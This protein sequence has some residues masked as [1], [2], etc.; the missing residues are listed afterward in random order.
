MC[1]LCSVEPAEAGAD[2]CKTC[3]PLSLRKQERMESVW[4][5][6]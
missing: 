6:V 3:V 2:E 1:D 5:S 4:N